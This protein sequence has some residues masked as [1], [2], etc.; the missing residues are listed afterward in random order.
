MTHTNE[1][2]DE[3]LLPEPEGINVPYIVTL[4]VASVLI[5]IAIVAALQGYFYNVQGQEILRKDV[6]ATNYE[7]NT[8]LTSQR[9]ELLGY[10]MVNPERGWV[11]IEIDQAMKRLVERAATQPAGAVPPLP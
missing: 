9:Q 2:A 4:G 1:P 7:L 5:L 10:R 11:Q 6:Q 3:R 8:Q